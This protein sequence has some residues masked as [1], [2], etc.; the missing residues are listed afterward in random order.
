MAI[1]GPAA[2]PDEPLIAMICVTPRK[3]ALLRD[4]SGA[5]FDELAEEEPG[6]LSKSD[7]SCRGFQGTIWCMDWG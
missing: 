1:A 6:T 3:P 4:V 5:R 7:F 2:R